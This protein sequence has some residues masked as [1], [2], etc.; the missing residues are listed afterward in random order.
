MP[1]TK[2]TKTQQRNLVNSTFA[3]VRNG[4]SITNARKTIANEAG[5]S[6]NTLFIWQHSF[7]LK[8]PTVIKT[9]DLVKNNRKV[10]LL[11]QNLTTVPVPNVAFLAETLLFPEASSLELILPAT[12]NVAPGLSVPIPTL[13]WVRTIP[14]QPV[15]CSSNEFKFKATGECPIEITVDPVAV[16][17]GFSNISPSLVWILP[18]ILILPVNLC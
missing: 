12:C 7:N 18:V 15:W 3:L 9:K 6:P 17:V 13:D 2:H 4:Q 8:T 16:P 14:L 10:K 1:K 5:L 11:S